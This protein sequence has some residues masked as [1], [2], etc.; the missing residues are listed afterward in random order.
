MKKNKKLLCPDLTP[1]KIE[2]QNPW[3]SVYNR[4]GY[5]TTETNE[6]QVAVL[7]VIENS[8]IV[9]VKVKR[10]VI[11]DCTWELPAGGCNKGESTLAAAQRE[12]FEETGIKVNADRLQPILTL[13][14]CPNRYPVHPYIFQINLTQKEYDAR[15]NHDKEI[16][17][18]SSFNLEEIKQMI[19]S[20]EIYIALPV[21]ILSRFILSKFNGLIR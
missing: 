2:H 10:P 12:L 4:G 19:I 20:A 3:F 14:V 18:V 16:E 15:D 17:Q 7:P 11:N 5:Y 8:R 9:M 1:I 21:V 6:N 13:S